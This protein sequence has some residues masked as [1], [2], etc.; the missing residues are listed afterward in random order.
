MM[1]RG[2]DGRMGGKAGTVRRQGSAR[3]CGLFMVIAPRIEQNQP[4]EVEI[5][6]A[7]RCGA[8]DTRR[9]DFGCPRE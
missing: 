6:D 2:L 5:A 4:A 3:E 1:Y 9:W 7:V 8:A